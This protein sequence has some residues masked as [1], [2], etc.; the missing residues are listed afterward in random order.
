MIILINED[1]HLNE[2]KR[3]VE[4]LGLEIKLG[5]GIFEGIGL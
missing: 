3:M 4:F 5:Y 2:I 1:N